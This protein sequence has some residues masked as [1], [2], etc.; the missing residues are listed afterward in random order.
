MT[1]LLRGSTAFETSLAKSS[2]IYS[3]NISLTALA[4]R[5][6]S[7]INTN[8]ALGKRGWRKHDL[9]YVY[10]SHFSTF[11]NICEDFFYLTYTYLKKSISGFFLSLHHTFLWRASHKPNRVS[12]YAQTPKT[13]LGLEIMFP[14]I[15]SSNMKIMNDKIFLFVYLC[16]CMLLCVVRVAR[17]IP[18]FPFG[19][20]C[21]SFSF[22]C[23]RSAR[24]S[25]HL[26]GV[27]IGIQCPINVLC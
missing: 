21:W 12:T 8:L 13:I 26:N 20:L 9:L 1:L 6:I 4:M 5:N 16:Y 17:W 19:S 18:L 11:W 3:L 10:D 24:R 27:S 14:G 25:L 23:L 22:A 15:I 2:S 7:S